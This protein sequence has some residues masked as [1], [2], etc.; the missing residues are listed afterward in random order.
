MDCSIDFDGNTQFNNDFYRERGGFNFAYEIVKPFGAIEGILDWAKE[1][2]SGDWRWQL[3]ELS[4][5]RKPG[6]YIF[7]F[8]SE[9]DYLSFILKCS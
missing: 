2:L 1:E 7:Y 4:S 8:D 6:R 3:I 5:E 9:R